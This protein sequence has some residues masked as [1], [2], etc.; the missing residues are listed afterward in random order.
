M[1]QEWAACILDSWVPDAPARADMIIIDKETI[2][3]KNTFP[4]LSIP[5]TEITNGAHANGGTGLYNSING[6][7]NLWQIY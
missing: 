1:H 4:R 7:K 6:S 2:N 3:N 5:R